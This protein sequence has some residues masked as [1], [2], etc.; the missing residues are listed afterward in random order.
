[1][2]TYVDDQSTKLLISETVKYKILG[3]KKEF[4]LFYEYHHTSDPLKK[5]EIKAAILKSNLRFVL[6]L[7]NDYHKT[8]GLPVNEYYAEGKLGL[9]EAFNKFD[10]TNGTKFISFAVFE[11]RR[12]MDMIT[13]ESDSMHIPVRLRKTVIAARKKGRDISKIKYGVLAD[14]AI[15]EQLSIYQPAKNDDINNSMT[16]ADMI[17]AEIEDSAENVY[18]SSLLKKQL[19]LS[20]DE[21]LSKEESS[22]L[23]KLYGLDGYEES[24]A[25]IAESTGR[26]KD[27]VRRMKNAALAKLRKNAS[28]LELGDELR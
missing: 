24:V 11:L 15:G 26:A 2:R 21:S 17:P 27:A 8:T 25:E 3:R 22:L 10:Y 16:I 18:E 4:A 1:M 13:N 7:A 12:H 19:E 20:M 28:M 9:V 14:N 5:D 6:N 23:R